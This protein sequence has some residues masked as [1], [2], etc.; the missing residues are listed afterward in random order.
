MRKEIL[1][2]IELLMNK[3]TK[4]FPKISVII[5]NY[6]DA[7]TLPLCLKA[8]FSSDYPDFEVIVVDDKSTDNSRELIKSFDIKILVHEKNRGQGAARNTGAKQANGE[9]LLFIDADACLKKDTLKKIANVFSEKN[10]IAA[11]VGLPD[12]TCVYKN[13]A[14]IHFNRRIYFN[15]LKLPDYINII[16]GTVAA[17]KKDVFLKIKGF[18][19]GITGVEDTEIGYRLVGLGYKI[20]YSKDISVTHHKK[21]NLFALFKNDFKRTV[22][23]L[24]FFLGK[25]Q[26]KTL[27]SEKRFIASPLYELLSPFATFFFF[28]FLLGAIVYRPLIFLSLFGFLMFLFLNL[29]YL[30][31]NLKEEGLS[32]SIKLFVLLLFDMLIVMFALFW[33]GILFLKGEKY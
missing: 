14:S 5:P 12:K 31:F 23:R 29:G 26:I 10:D 21:I 32:T 2:F 9:I 22:D 19:E 18:N 7:E 16:H 11:V 17:I 1:K 3:E 25:K 30:S 20:Y 24:K 8:V 6:N 27:I 13:L 28:F 4:K 15:F 33:G